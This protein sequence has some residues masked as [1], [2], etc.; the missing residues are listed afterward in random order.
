MNARVKKKIVHVGFALFAKNPGEKQFTKVGIFAGRDTAKSY[1]A[2][3]CSRAK[4]HIEGV[5]VDMTPVTYE[6][7]RSS[8]SN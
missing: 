5:R 2:R 7:A 6:D 3:Y 8:K 4:L 1:A